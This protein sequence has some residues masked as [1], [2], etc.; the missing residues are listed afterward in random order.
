MTWLSSAV[1]LAALVIVCLV[2]GIL[3]ACREVEDIWTE[4]DEWDWWENQRRL[5]R[6]DD[7][8]DWPRSRTR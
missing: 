4:E 6:R 7:P 8:D 2:A 3:I 5:Q 1:A